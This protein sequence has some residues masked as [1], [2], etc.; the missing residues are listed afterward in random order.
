MLLMVVVV[1]IEVGCQDAGQAQAL[2]SQIDTDKDGFISRDEM[3]AEILKAIQEANMDILSQDTSRV[4]LTVNKLFKDL[5][6]DQMNLLQFIEQFNTFT[7]I[8]Q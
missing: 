3:T 4:Q 6:S 5:E 8:K 2:F 1:S 7:I